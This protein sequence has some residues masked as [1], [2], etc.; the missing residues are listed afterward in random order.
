MWHKQCCRIAPTGSR[1]ADM[2]WT[3]RI[4]S[5]T[6]IPSGMIIMNSWQHKRAGR[7]GPVASLFAPEFFGLVKA[8]AVRACCALLQAENS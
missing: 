5:Q 4:T 3:I 7:F 8:M 1:V 6:K 2:D